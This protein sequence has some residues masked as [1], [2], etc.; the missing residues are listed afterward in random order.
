[1]SC[2]Y[3]VMCQNINNIHEVTANPMGKCV[4]PFVAMG[5]CAWV[6]DLGSAN[7]IHEVYDLFT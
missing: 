5:N 6:V 2:S 3:L 4:L 7:D 1:M